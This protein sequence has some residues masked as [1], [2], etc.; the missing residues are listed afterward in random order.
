VREVKEQT[1]A[2]LEQT[3]VEAAPSNSYYTRCPAR[4]LGSDFVARVAQPLQEDRFN[5]KIEDIM[6]HFANHEELE[7]SHISPRLMINLDKSGFGASKSG[8]QKSC[9]VIVLQSLSKK[10][11]FKET[12]DFHF[13]IALCAISAFGNVLRSSLIDKR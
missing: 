1:V 10:P 7:I 12:S 4:S 9:K 11:V 3:S 8:R 5:V 6:R 13:I 2:E